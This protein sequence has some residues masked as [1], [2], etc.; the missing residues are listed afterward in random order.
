MEKKHNAAASDAIRLIYITEIYLFSS[1]LSPPPPGPS[2]PETQRWKLSY[3]FENIV[4]SVT[5]YLVMNS[6]QPLVFHIISTKETNK[7]S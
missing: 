1:L 6:L 4:C 5:D 2:L 3:Q 7:M